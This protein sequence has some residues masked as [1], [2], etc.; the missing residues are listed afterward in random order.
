MATSNPHAQG[1]DSGNTVVI[2]QE[3]DTQTPGSALV[4]AVFAGPGLL[5]THTGI[6]YGT[7]DVTL[8]LPGQPQVA[9][10]T[11][12]EV[13]ID[14]FGRVVGGTFGTS[15]ALSDTGVTPGTYGSQS[16][17]G[18]YTVDV[19]GRL[20]NAVN[21]PILITTSQVSNLGLWTGSTNITTLG[22]VVTGTWNAGVVGAPYGG[23]GN[24]SWTQYAVVYADTT[25]SLAGAAP[26]IAAAKRF[27]SMTGTGTVGAAPAWSG[28]TMADIVDLSTWAGSTS[29]TTIG[30]ITTGTWNGTVITPVFGGTGLSSY[31][32]GDLL[33]ANTTTSLTRLPDVVV[34]N[35]LLSG[36]VN[37]QP[38]YGK[39]GLAS[40][41][42]GTLPTANGG[43]GSTTAPTS[44]VTFIGKSDGTYATALITGTSPIVVTP[45]SGTLTLS[46]AVS[47]VT[48]GTYGSGSDIPVV[49]LNSSGH[50]TNISTVPF[51]STGIPT[52]N[53][54]VGQVVVGNGPTGLTSFAAYTYTTASD[55][56]K[57]GTGFI[58]P[59]P[60]YT[61]TAFGVS[62][63]SKQWG[64]GQDTVNTYVNAKTGGS[65][66]FTVDGL[67]KGSV[68]VST[69][70]LPVLS[71]GTATVTTGL[72]LPYL[73]GTPGLLTVN[74]SG[75]ISTTGAGKISVD[76]GDTPGYLLNEK[77][78]PGAGITFT[79][80]TSGF[81]K[82]IVVNS[83]TNSWRPVSYAAGAVYVVL[84]T[85]DVVVVNSNSSPSTIV[86]LPTP[87][88]AYRGR[89][90][91]VQNAA[92]SGSTTID[93]PS[94]PLVGLTPG[95]STAYGKLEFICVDTGT[96]GYA[97]I[98][99]A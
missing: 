77:L 55:T 39:V 90:I 95:I 82:T 74:G 61:G 23:T 75:V 97:W 83:R 30:T 5:E 68:S 94:G 64:F 7:G 57:V 67:N 76:A 81:G 18:V 89:L 8:F 87:G 6:D 88:V 96:L 70:T 29:I 41:V 72:V 24:S 34:G 98:S 33:T 17:V 12:T 71:T 80:T 84:D 62:V 22:T 37:A 11:L 66:V 21:T 1:V 46:H 59:N 27:F 10:Q 56:L 15:T 31:A 32:I 40:H 45:G 9:G 44:G 42:T 86:R 93:C 36:G 50:I 54:P 3:I 85:D 92:P 63:A 79:Q 69:W 43:T 78:A 28:I 2:R 48:A 20:T 73:G 91:T 26:N 19:K 58:A 4:T 25:T 38:L 35:V 99:R 16:S 60:D 51:A 53:Q 14:D 52:L 49:T 65:V 13:I 47:G